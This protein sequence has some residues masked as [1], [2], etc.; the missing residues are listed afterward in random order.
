MCYVCHC[1][2]ISDSLLP[3]THVKLPFICSYFGLLTEEIRKRKYIERENNH[4]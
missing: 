3:F 4:K 2:S 1:N